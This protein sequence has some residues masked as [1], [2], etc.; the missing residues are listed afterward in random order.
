MP[1]DYEMPLGEPV[2]RF[3]NRCAIASAEVTRAEP[4]S[5]A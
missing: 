2:P 1:R 4:E 5:A 3:A